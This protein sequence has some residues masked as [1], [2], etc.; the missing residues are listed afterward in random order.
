MGE[1][2][3][4]APPSE[5]QD[6]LAHPD[7]RRMDGELNGLHA[8]IEREQYARSLQTIR[9]VGD[10]ALK[11]ALQT[12]EGQD[13]RSTLKKDWD[14]VIAEMIKSD[15]ELGQRLEISRLDELRVANGQAVTN[16]GEPMVDLIWSGIDRAKA[17]AEKD[18]R[19]ETQVRRDHADLWSARRVDRMIAGELDCN[20]RVV[21]SLDPKEAIERD[22]AEFWTQK[23]AGFYYIPGMAFIQLYHYDGTKLITGSFSVDFSDKAA[24][25]EVL[26]EAGVE[27]SHDESTDTLVMHGIEKTLTAD[28]AVSLPYKL[29]AR[30]YEKRGKAK[31]RLSINE[32]LEA[33]EDQ[34]DR[35]FDMLYIPVTESV[36]AGAHGKPA[37]EIVRAFA[38]GLLQRPDVLKPG[39]VD[40]LRQV[41]A[42]APFTEDMGRLMEGLVRYSAVEGLRGDLKQRL[43]GVPA[44]GHAA[45]K[46]GNTP[47]HFDGR[48]AHN[49]ASQRYS[50]GMSYIDYARMRA[51]QAS[52]GVAAGRS[53]GAC[54]NIDDFASDGAKKAAAEN[55]GEQV[56]ARPDERRSNQEAYAGKTDKDSMDKKNWK[57]KWQVCGIAACPSR[58]GK[59]DRPE[60]TLCGPCGYCMH[61]CQPLFERGKTDTEIAAIHAKR[62]KYALAA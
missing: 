56:D 7:L 38:Q 10:A 27:V 11:G 18:K 36:A 15:E 21:I 34:L 19:F 49:D 58:G 22:G 62:S 24:W 53:Y 29:R 14:S 26:R 45:L 3:A 4:F 31:Q 61:D 25:I 60:K 28:E 54:A 41:A 33:H 35:D 13:L 2:T 20:T 23:S 42:G 9:R 59:P 37:H 43:H 12:P 16:S 48:I 30:Y 44:I 51:G 47:S 39:I 32:F 46:G 5:V 57:L 6:M 1:M 52:E 40:A 8:Q 50:G 55:N 17:A